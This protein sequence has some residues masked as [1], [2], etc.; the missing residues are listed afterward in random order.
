MENLKTVLDELEQASRDYGQAAKKQRYEESQRQAKY[1][2]I[3]KM[4]QSNKSI[5]LSYMWF[6][7]KKEFADSID[8][9]KESRI[10]STVLNDMRSVWQQDLSGSLFPDAFHFIPDERSLTFLP[11]LSFILSVPFVLR[12]PYISRDDNYFYIIDNPVKKEWVF[13]SPYVAPSQW[14]GALRSAM[15]RKIVEELHRVGDED[16]FMKKRLQLYRLFG[17]EKDGTEDYLNKML[18]LKRIGPSPENTDK[19]QQEEWFKLFNN[20]IQRVQNEF[21]TILR[22]NRYQASDIEGFQG[23]LYFYP[24]FFNEI[25]IEVINPH[26]RKSGAG[27]QPIYFE[28]VPAGGKGIF[29]LIYTPLSFCLL[30]DAEHF[31]EVAKDLEI[32]AQGIYA[33][34]TTFG[35][36]AKTTNGY[37]VIEEILE[38]PGMLAIKL[39]WQNELCETFDS[40]V[41]L[42]VIVKEIAETLRKEG[43]H[44]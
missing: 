31:Q 1:D 20:E 28:C 6:L 34:L 41:Q 9:N 14:K 38:S 18:A 26:D 25:G 24:T 12:K 21:N 30:N 7:A 19:K 16:A 2:M 27:S 44:E 35:F 8:N 36:G 15:M 40:L 22:K 23:R 29:S 4:K 42:Q 11:Y 33:M 39:P 3:E 43:Q 37:G 5:H 13:K 10:F 32:L 17:N